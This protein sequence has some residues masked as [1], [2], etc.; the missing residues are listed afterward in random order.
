[1]RVTLFLCGV[2]ENLKTRQ[3]KDL[4]PF[5][6]IVDL[7]LFDRLS[8]QH[9]MLVGRETG[10]IAQADGVDGRMSVFEPFADG[11]VFGKYARRVSVDHVNGGH[12]FFSF[13]SAQVKAQVLLTFQYILIF[14]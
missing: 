10:K 13:T 12:V 2:V 3:V 7:A 4:L 8:E 14:F 1:M 6:L 9:G 11:L 5:G